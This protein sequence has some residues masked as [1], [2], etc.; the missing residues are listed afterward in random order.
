MKN[1]FGENFLGKNFLGEI[2]LGENWAIMQ[3]MIFNSVFEIDS[4]LE[5]KSDF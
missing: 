4:V 3:N 2:F 5:N 1:F